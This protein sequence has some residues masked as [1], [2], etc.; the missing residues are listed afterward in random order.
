MKT[1][2]EYQKEY[3]FNNSMI[4]ESFKSKIL[5]EISDQLNNR[6]KKQKEEAE[7]DD[8]RYHRSPDISAT[9]KKLFTGK[10]IGI[11]WSEVSDDI[12][13]EY[14]KDDTEGIKLVKRITS[15]RSNSF[16]GLVILL[17]TTDPDSPKYR[18]I[19]IGGGNGQSGNDYYSFTN[20]W[21]FHRETFRPSDAE[22]FL[23]EK[24]L[25]ADLTD[26]KKSYSDKTRERYNNIS[27]ALNPLNDADV[28]EF[29]YKQIA[30]R[31]RDRY[32]KYLAKIKADKEANDDYVKKVTEYSQKIFH[33]AEELSKNPIKYAKY[34]YEVSTLLSYLSGKKTWVPSHGRHQG[35]YSGKNGLFTILETYLK[36]KLSMAKGTSYDSE[37]TA[38]DAAKKALDDT[39]KK[40][41]AYLPKFDLS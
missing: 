27:G 33:V 3:W 1:I 8:G 10:W 40:I 32:K 14:S 22:A 4:T 37:K 39:F 21:S 24:F 36:A 19:L 25:F 26:V 16:P 18:G 31:N 28:R 13:K 2:L 41:D 34:E 15:S 20:N 12:F 35:Y 29:E 5:Q 6:I 9:F 23:T 30:E 38:Y 17:N 7:K 11:S